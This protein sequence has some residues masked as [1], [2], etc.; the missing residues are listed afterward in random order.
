MAVSYAACYYSIYVEMRQGY[1]MIVGFAMYS[2]I[3][4][5]RVYLL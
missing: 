5:S 2:K 1:L 4:E 3:L